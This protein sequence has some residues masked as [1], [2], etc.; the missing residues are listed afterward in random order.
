MADAQRLDS[1]EWT[2]VDLDKVVRF[3][4]RGFSPEQIAAQLG[5]PPAQVSER[6]KIV[7]NRIGRFH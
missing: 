1:Q 6:L 3:H 2:D 7:I 4:D 5:R